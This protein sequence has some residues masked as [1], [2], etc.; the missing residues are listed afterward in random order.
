MKLSKQLHIII[1]FIFTLI[2]TGNFI[3]SMNNF[4]SYLE[5]E[6][7]TK[8]QDTA[9]L[10]GMNLKGL[11]SD[12]YDPEIKS[13]ISAIANRGFYK[14]IRL[15]DVEFNF[16]K[17]DLIKNIKLKEEFKQFEIKD[18]KIDKN[19]GEILSPADDLNIENELLDLESESQ[20]HNNIYS[21][22]PSKTFHKNHLKISFTMYN[23][24]N[25][26]EISIN[27]PI[28]IVLTKVTKNE[29]FDSVPQWFIDLIHIENQESKSEISDGWKTSAIIY[30]ST[31]AGDA[32]LK[33]YQ[34]AKYIIY[35]SIISFLVSF[36]ILL[37]FLRFILKPLENID[38][39]AK[40]ISNG[41][42]N[43]ITNIPWTI[44]LKNVSISMN[45]MS[46]KVQDIF[47]KGEES[48]KRNKELLYND[49]ITKLFNRRYLMIKIPEILKIANKTNG[50]SVIFIALGGAQILNQSLGRQKADNLFLEFANSLKKITRNY[51]NRVISRVNGTE[52]TLLLHDCD[53]SISS[54]IARRINRSF[55]KLIKANNLNG[56][57]I[58]INIGIFRYNP[59]TLISELMTKTDNALSIAKSKENDNTHL[60][61]EKEDENVLGKEQWREII[62]NSIVNNSISTNS[63]QVLNTKSNTLYHNILEMK[64]EENKNKSYK[65][66][67][68][69]ANTINLG[70]I[71]KVYI[72]ALK[73]IFIAKDNN[74]KYSI[75]LLNEFIKDKNSID[76]LE[77]LFK[78]T[79]NDIDLTFEV[80]D[81]FTIANTNLIKSY[82]QLFNKFK[83]KF[84]IN[85]FTG[86]ADSY[87]YL[88]QLNPKYIKSDCSY[89]LDQ[90]NESISA[91]DIITDT[92]SIDVVATSVETKEQ[93]KELN[94]RHI[95]YISLQ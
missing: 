24:L 71:D 40:E 37:V 8:S 13:T 66:K 75:H 81:T 59:N 63:L 51:E 46:L 12:K 41:K 84:A 29:K 85:S 55:S 56:D 92:L 50:G 61:E 9:T 95:Y 49:P 52:F 69:I 44:E 25:S 11:I 70:Q 32:Y 22:I 79:P 57:D 18:I 60:Y 43:K 58:F 3:I 33:L 21:F 5:I 93:I 23:D 39:L 64:I 90:S 19:D 27:L 86:E 6:S 67:E 76:K 73:N 65:N 26:I 80:S 78:N 17:N 30:V 89:L 16:T 38:N 91:L 88:E 94:K 1:L 62:E 14:E 2:F 4:K 34:Q 20:G 36:I 77:D 68:F 53:A 35:Y 82:V 10:L 31:N 83:F 15:E 7:K 87:S 47:K 74:T 45:N 54:D 72:S 48:A 42:F 28:Q